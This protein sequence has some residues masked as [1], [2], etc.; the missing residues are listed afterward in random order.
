MQIAQ[1]KCKTVP[2]TRGGDP[3]AARTWGLYFPLFPAHA[4]VI[5]YAANE[6]YAVAAVPRTRG[7]ILRSSSRR[8]RWIAV[9][10]TRGGDPLIPGSY[11]A[12]KGCSPHTR[13]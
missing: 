4:G 1:K 9:P 2:R 12:L 7:V 8:K 5:P 13:G 11:P 6:R 10:R 3:R